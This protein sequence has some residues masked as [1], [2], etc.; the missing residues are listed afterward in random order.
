[1][2][3]EGRVGLKKSTTVCLSVWRLAGGWRRR[4]N[5]RRRRMKKM[6]DGVDSRSNS[7]DSKT[8]TNKRDAVGVAQLAT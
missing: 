8:K 3:V 5:M 6:M 1:M 7:G 4:G 2:F